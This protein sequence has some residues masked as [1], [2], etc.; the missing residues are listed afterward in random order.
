MPYSV[1]GYRTRAEECVRLANL[2]RDDMVQTELLRLRQS[3]LRI[4]ERLEAL[5]EKKTP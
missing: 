5:G 3:Y 2:A 1:T 4:A